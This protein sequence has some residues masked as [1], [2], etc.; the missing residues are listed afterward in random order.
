MWANSVLIIALA[1]LGEAGLSY[2]GLGD[3]DS[4]S[5][6]TVLYNGFQAGAINAGAWWYVV[7]PG[8]AI[9]L[10]VLAFFAVGQ[11]I[12]E[13]ADPRAEAGMSDGPVLRVEDLRVGY[14]DGADIE[15]VSGVSFELHRGEALGLAGESGCGKTTTALSILKLL[16]P[17]LRQFSGTIDLATDDGIVHV[18]RRTERGMRDLRWSEVSLVFQGALNALN[19]VQRISRQIGGAIRLHDRDADRGAVDARVSELLERVGI[20]PARQP[21]P[22]RV[23]GRHAPA[24]HDRAR[25]GLRPEVVI[26][27]E[28]TTA[29]DVMTQAQVL[30]LLEE[31]RRDLGLALL[32]ITHDLGVIAETCDRVALMY[33]GS[34]VETGP[35]ETV[36]GTPQHPYTQRL[37]GAFPQIG[38]ERE[39]PPAIPGA[40]P[41]PA[42]RPPA[43][44]STHAATSRAR[45]AGTA[46]WSCGPWETTTSRPACSRRSRRRRSPEGCDEH[47]HPARGGGH[48]AGRGARA[49]GDVQPARPGRARARRRRP[50][51]APER[52]ARRRR[53]V[54]LRQDDARAHAAR[55]RGAERRRAALRGLVARPRR[56]AHAAAQ[57]ADGLPGSVPVAQPAHARERAGAGAAAHAGHARGERVLR[58]ATALEDAGLAPAERFWHRY[59]HELSGGQRQRVAIASALAP[60]PAAS[61]A[62][63]PSRRSTS[64]CAP[65]CCTCCWACA[66]R[67]GWRCS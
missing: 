33:A 18:Q 19:P 8:L 62:T 31:L 38:N 25:A 39:L 28:P 29:L 36:F 30:A 51:V 57:G 40:P 24:R 44:A 42:I 43:A 58:A 2:F 27:D 23:L 13:I 67:A 56:L 50:G 35:T 41:D 7:P 37:L 21:V 48:A 15:I 59:P 60:D 4:F 63:S 16:D 11:V 54:G 64:R 10:F 55:A 66:A 45:P 3:P 34:I 17:G 32:L 22:A 52:G 47:R 6:G 20:S 65:R 1:V 5:W 12:E 26:A 9:T 53:R 49:R 14:D 61:S 46:R